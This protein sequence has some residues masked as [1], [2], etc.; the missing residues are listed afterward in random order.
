[1]GD[2]L[3]DF[4]QLTAQYV[5]DME[6]VYQDYQDQKEAIGED[7]IDEDAEEAVRAAV[8]AALEEVKTLADDYFNQMMNLTRTYLDNLKELPEGEQPDQDLPATGPEREQRPEA[9]PL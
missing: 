4:G 2:T 1:M 6:A 9:N 5:K 3:N 8:K 7:L